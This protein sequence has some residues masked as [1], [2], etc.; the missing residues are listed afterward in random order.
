MLITIYYAAI[1]ALLYVYLT[2]RVIGIRRIAKV[3][4]GDGGNE[5]LSRA[6]RV[7]ANFSEYVPFTLLLIYFL[8]TQNANS[9]V[10]HILCSLLLIARFLH[11]YGVSNINEKLQFRILGMIMNISVLAI[12]SLYLLLTGIV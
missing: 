3:S 5:K 6:I 10:L 9:I 4:I 11:A 2:F 8:E 7:H 12:S 1:L